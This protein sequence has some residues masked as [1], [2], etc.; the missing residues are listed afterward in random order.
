M[1]EE[2]CTHDPEFEKVYSQYI[3]AR[4]ALK[5]ARVARGFLPVVI[6]EAALRHLK[7]PSPGKK[8]RQG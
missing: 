2:E 6:P 5:Q 1:D 4:D 8:Q 7:S 3:E